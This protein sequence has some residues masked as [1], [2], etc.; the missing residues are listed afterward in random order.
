MG[1]ILNLDGLPDRSPLGKS[2]DK[3]LDDAVKNSQGN[4][5]EVQVDRDGALGEISTTKNGWTVAGFGQWLRGN[6]WNA[7]GKVRKTW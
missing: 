7:G 6:G 4:A 5:L 3:A 1:G 2:I